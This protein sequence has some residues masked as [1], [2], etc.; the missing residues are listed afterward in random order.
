MSV[1]EVVQALDAY[2]RDPAAPSVGQGV[3]LET[4]PPDRAL[5]AR[6]PL[7]WL[8]YSLVPGGGD[9]ALATGLRWLDV[10]FDV[11]AHGTPDVGA[12]VLL[13]L[14]HELENYLD[15]W[16]PPLPAAWNSLLAFTQTQEL[17]QED[18]S[19]D[20]LTGLAH[21][22]RWRFQAGMEPG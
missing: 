5:D 17:S 11:L 12:G 8:T 21:G 19:G 3:W 4:Y 10:S 14:A 16:L 6:R 18:W 20:R 13:G 9:R 22:A 15:N 2:L 1:G 7:T